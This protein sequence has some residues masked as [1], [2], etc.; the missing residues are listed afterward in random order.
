VSKLHLHG[1]TRLAPQREPVP[2]RQGS[3]PAWDEPLRGS[4]AS[5]GR[6]LEPGRLLP[7]PLA[8]NDRLGRDQ[9]YPDFSSRGAHLFERGDGRG[10]DRGQSEPDLD[11]SIKLIIRRAHH[12][13]C[14]RSEL[15]MSLRDD[16]VETAIRVHYIDDVIMYFDEQ[17][18][19]EL[20]QRREQLNEEKWQRYRSEGLC[21]LGTPH[22]V[23]VSLKMIVNSLRTP[24]LCLKVGDL[25]GEGTWV[26]G[27]FDTVRA[28]ESR[29]ADAIDEVAMRIETGMS[30]SEAEELVFEPGQRRRRIAIE[31][32][33]DDTPP[34]QWRA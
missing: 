3:S 23:W 26:E 5:P 19:R 27:A 8:N 17:R 11:P 29:V 7:V 4:G 30:F 24:A 25:M 21:Y 13:S 22:W 20:V 15:R 10:L 32:H 9:R 33:G 31:R 28:I 34:N 14:Y 2:K 18:D 1:L 12:G 6:A 16:A